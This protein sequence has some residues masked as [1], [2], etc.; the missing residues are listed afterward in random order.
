M[1]TFTNLCVRRGPRVLIDDSTFTI[2]RG[3]KVGI[4]GANGTGKTTLFQLIL[5]EIAQDTGDFDMP[6]NLT[7]AHVAQEVKATDRNAVDFYTR[8]LKS[9]ADTPQNPELPRF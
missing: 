3:H 7:V 1:L 8:P 2:H 4:T 9:P 6:S 5:G